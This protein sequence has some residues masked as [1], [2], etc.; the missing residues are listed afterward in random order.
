MIAVLLLRLW[1][2]ALLLLI[3]VAWFIVER[4]DF[5]AFVNEIL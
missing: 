1:W 2:V 4:L 3:V 5:L